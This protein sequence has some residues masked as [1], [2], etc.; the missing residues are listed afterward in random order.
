MLIDWFTVGAQLLNFAVLVWLMKRFL[1]RPILQA[2]DAREKHIAQALAQ[3]EADKAQAAQD[4]ERLRSLHEALDL[5]RAALLSQ[6]SEE[7][8]TERQ[9]LIAQ[10]RAAADALSARRQE[11]L[12]NDARQLNQAISRRAGQEVFAIARQTLA[13]LA[14]AALEARIAE[15]FIARLRVLDAP[16]RAALAEALKT[17][18][19]PARLRSTFELPAAQRAALQHALDAAFSTQ[20]ALV[21]E[22]APELV[23]GIELTVNG[24]KLA[25]SIADYL[26]SLEKSVSELIETQSA[27]PGLAQS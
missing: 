4:S 26:A 2:V 20:V 9:R 6:A 7:A 19:E 16:A 21:F 25:W 18:R 27:A 10:A 3:A 23:S 1:Y 11:T 22:T 15:V 17:A 24:Q 5:Q 12:I 14:N 8:D 13:D